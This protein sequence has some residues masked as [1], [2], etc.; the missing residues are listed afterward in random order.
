MAGRAVG[1]SAATLSCGPCVR[2]AFHRT[3]LFR[4]WVTVID[5]VGRVRAVARVRAG[6]GLGEHRMRCLAAS[7]LGEKIAGD[8]FRPT[9]QQISDAGS[10]RNYLGSH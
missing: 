10:G 5:T 6:V 2:E 3:R 1:R 9:P 4:Q 8:Q 7:Q